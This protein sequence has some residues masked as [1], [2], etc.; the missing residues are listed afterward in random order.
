MH[1]ALICVY[2]LVS[3][4]YVPKLDERVYPNST[5]TEI[6][7]DL[8]F[9]DRRQLCEGLKVKT[10][11]SNAAQD[12]DVMFHV[13]VKPTFGGPPTVDGTRW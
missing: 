6:P 2:F 5:N 13:D 7:W 12:Q 9:V 10:I 3:G 8:E 4:R 1:F 11:L